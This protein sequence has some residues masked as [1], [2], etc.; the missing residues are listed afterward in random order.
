MVLTV[1]ATSGT[2]CTISRSTVT[3]TVAWMCVID[4]NQAGTSTYACSVTQAQQVITVVPAPPSTAPAITSASSYSVPAGQSFSFV[5]TA[6]GTPAP[7]ISVS[8]SLPSGV[9]LSG[10]SN[11]TA[12]VLGHRPPQPHLSIHDHRVQ[13]QGPLRDA[14]FHTDDLV[15][16][17]VAAGSVE[18]A[19]SGRD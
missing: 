18:Y 5:V 15:S 12:N 1:D 4:A 16:S 3:F 7:T 6:T 2:A 13:R 9:T 10:G 14:E 11:G 8:G 17:G 19:V